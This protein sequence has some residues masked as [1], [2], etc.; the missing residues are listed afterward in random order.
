MN[1]FSILCF[2]VIF[3]FYLHISLEII[4]QLEVHFKGAYNVLFRFISLKDECDFL[5]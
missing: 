3:S 4:N 5:F 1:F 2:Y